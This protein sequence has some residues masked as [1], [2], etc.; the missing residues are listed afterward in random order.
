MLR[1]SGWRDRLDLAES[2]RQRNLL[3]GTASTAEKPWQGKNLCS[4]ALCILVVERMLDK[5]LSTQVKN[6][7]AFTKSELQNCCPLEIQ[8]ALGDALGYYTPSPCLEKFPLFCSVSWAEGWVRIAW[9]T[10]LS[11]W[12]LAQCQWGEVL[13]NSICIWFW[14][15]KLISDP[16]EGWSAPGG[17]WNCTG[18]GV[19]QGWKHWQE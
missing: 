5:E 6:L 12:V 3:C 8:K 17:L 16:F 18:V 14:S 4:V 13:S 10:A 2:K 11:P 19:S 1:H 15:C 7:N 9:G